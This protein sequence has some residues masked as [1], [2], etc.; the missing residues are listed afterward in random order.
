MT[1]NRRAIAVAMAVAVLSVGFAAPPASAATAFTVSGTETFHPPPYPEQLLPG[2]F[3]GDTIVRVAYPAAIFGMDASIG[4]AASGLTSATA[5]ATGPIVLAGFSQGAIAVAYEKKRIMSL[6]A[7]QRPAT[8]R[9]TF[10]TIGDPTGPGG[11]M[12]FLPFAVPLL[13]LTPIIPPDTEYDSVI[14]NGEY[15]GWG[16]FP[17]RPWNLIS[18]A[19]ALLGIAYVH[20]RY[21]VTPGGLDLTAVPAGDIT[22]TTNS[23]GGTTTSYLIPTPNLPLVQ[24]LRDIGVPAPIVDALQNSLKPIVDAGYVRNDPKPTAAQAVTTPGGRGAAVVAPRPQR[25]TPASATGRAAAD[26]A[27]R[28]AAAAARASAAA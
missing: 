28:R 15:D 24:P 26:S 16:D 9:L 7:D 23:L 6:P 25:A 10:V 3:A 17:D 1:A 12:R 5:S 14:V 20:G 11:I 22:V 8:D 4:I 27:P 19:N 18:L 21:E 2:Y 13:N